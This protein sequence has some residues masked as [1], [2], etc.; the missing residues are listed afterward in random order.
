MAHHAYKEAT[1]P[2]SRGKKLDHLRVREGESGGHVVE[3]HYADDGMVFHKPTSHVFGEGEGGD[4]LAHI[5]K[6][7]HISSGAKEE[8]EEQ[9]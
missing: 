2:S 4:L 6:H 3:H 8:P 7:A 9:E 1:T 5:A